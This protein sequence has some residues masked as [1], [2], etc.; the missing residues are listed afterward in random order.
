R[1]EAGFPSKN[2]Y[3]EDLDLIRTND[4]AYRQRSLDLLHQ[5]YDHKKIDLIVT[6]EG[7]ARDLML[8][9]GKDMFP[10]A[11]I[12]SILSA[13]TIT[14]VE[15][16]RRILQI[17]S[18]LDMSGTLT[19]AV[20][21]LPNTGRVFIVLGN[22]EDE[23]RWE[24]DAKKQFA[25]WAGKLEFEYST[26]L[27]YEETLARISSLPPDTVVIYIAFYRD[28]TGRAF[29]PAEVARVITRTA[30]SPVFGV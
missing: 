18:V 19:T 20:S 27:T 26:G 29:V 8:K 25:P 28:K 3:F 5:K 16:P 24:L 22:S 17:P 13:D 2:I 15:P 4:K 9:E 11:P 30:N 14:A 1:D 7:L 10:T 12:L 21:L 23:Q 6:V